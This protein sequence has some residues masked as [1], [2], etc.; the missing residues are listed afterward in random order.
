MSNDLKIKSEA[1]GVIRLHGEWHLSSLDKSVQTIASVP[2]STNNQFRRYMFDVSTTLRAGSNLLRIQFESAVS[3]ADA[4]AKEYPYYVPDMFNMSSAQYGFPCRNF[5]R[6]EQVSV[7]VSSVKI[8]RLSTVFKFDGGLPTSESTF[9]VN[10]GESTFNHSIFL[11]KSQVK[12]W[13]PRN[14]GQSTTYT[15][16]VTL[17]NE[18][19]SKVASHVFQCGFRTC[20][21]IQDTLVQ[22]KPGSAFKFRV[23]GMDI[24]AK[25]SN[26]I[27]GHVFDKQMTTEKKRFACALYP[28]NKEFLDNVKLEVSDQVRRL[29]IHPCIVLWSGNNEN[30]EFM[31]KGWDEATVRNPYIFAVDY[32]KLYVETIMSTLQTLDTSRSFISTSPSAGLISTT[33]YTERYVLRDDE[34]GL[35]GDV[36]FY[37]YKHNGLHVEYYPNSRFVSEY[38]AQSMC[39][40]SSWKTISSTD[41]WHP[42][43]KLSVHRN[44]H[45]NGQREMLE[46]IEYQF[47][48][49]NNLSKY[50][51]SD[52]ESL[53][54]VPVQQRGN[55]FDVFCYLTQC[56]QARSITA[57]TEHYGQ[58]SNMEAS[59][60]KPLHY[61]MKH[62]FADILVS[63][64]QPAGSRTFNVHISNDRYAAIE[65]FMIV[66]S[67]K[68]DDNQFETGSSIPFSVDGHSSKYISQVKSDLLGDGSGDNSPRLLFATATVV[69][70]D[71]LA[72]MN[73]QWRED[74]LPGATESLS[75]SDHGIVWL[76]WSESKM[77]GYFE[78]NA[79]WLLP[80]EPKRV[81]YYGWDNDLTITPSQTDAMDWS[82]TRLPGFIL[83]QL[84]MDVRGQGLQ[85]PRMPEDSEGPQLMDIADAKA[86]LT[87]TN[88]PTYDY[89]HAP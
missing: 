13:W 9:S 56:V 62:S 81:I 8:Q 78:E 72:L 75:H 18:S 19:G 71:R 29:M 31:V 23:N 76:E 10:A 54:N 79:F 88:Y 45:G 43:S 5:I 80:Q 24:F 40:Y 46:Q 22:G 25:G 61:Y 49:P 35:Y 57:Q 32:Y 42:L 52:P 12:L 73:S 51:H 67:Y 33:P 69:T 74:H 41:D 20:E 83:T 50:Y 21:L 2:G 44:H 89:K 87:A 3:Y 85:Q 17:V 58:A 27:P 53:S 26:W 84:V 15:V 77:E 82:M 39:S 16:E 36:H 37:D 70:G 59:R 34:R 68:I 86:Y 14:Y 63:G 48:L 6:K 65:G 60:W 66:R 64:Y 55:L 4:K 7:E 1:A 30:Q 11:K 28:T 47:Q 38:G